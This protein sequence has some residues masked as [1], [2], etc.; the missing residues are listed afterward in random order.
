MYVP[1]DEFKWRLTVVTLL[2][3]GGKEGSIK[4]E[5]V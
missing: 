3:G 5:Q 4:T 1:D 2:V